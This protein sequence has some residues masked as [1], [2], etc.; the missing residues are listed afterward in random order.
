MTPK[1]DSLLRCSMKKR[2][3][4]KHLLCLIIPVKQFVLKQLHFL[5]GE[6]VGVWKSEL[7]S[8]ICGD[9]QIQ[10]MKFKSYLVNFL[11]NS[12]QWNAAFDTKVLSF[13]SQIF[14]FLFPLKSTMKIWKEFKNISCCIFLPHHSVHNSML[15][16]SFSSFT[17]FFTPISPC[18]FSPYNLIMLC[19]IV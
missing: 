6:E 1:L 13:C 9:L 18:F 19:K 3:F 5:C 2:N 7:T 14:F 8:K 15:L 10:H 4:K 11:L 17:Q 12:S 16:F